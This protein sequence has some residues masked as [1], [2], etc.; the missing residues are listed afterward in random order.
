MKLK[1]FVRKKLNFTYTSDIIPRRDEQ[2]IHQGKAWIVGAISHNIDEKHIVLG[3]TCRDHYY[4]KDGEPGHF[5]QRN[6]CSI[7]GSIQYS[8]FDVTDTST[9]P[10]TAVPIRIPEGK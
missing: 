4:E 7:C 2:I 6:I 1:C 3:L 8:N 5:G 9:T 10:Y